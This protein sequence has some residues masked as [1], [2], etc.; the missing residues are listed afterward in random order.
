M[1]DRYCMLR[2][3]R[4][5]LPDAANYC[6]TVLETIA[7]GREKA[8]SHFSIDG[9]VLRKLAELAAIK[10]GKEARKAKAAQAEYT[11]AEREWLMK[12]LPLFIRRAA[13]VAFDPGV[14]RSRIALA[15]LPLLP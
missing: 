13:E 6:L 4:T 8:S 5:T 11:S 10:G 12:A 2:E 15:D 7:G 1:F 9:K 14:P 3:R